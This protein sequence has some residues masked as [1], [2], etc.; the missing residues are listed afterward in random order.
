MP[1]EPYALCPMPHAL[2]PVV[3]HLSEK[4]YKFVILNGAKHNEESAGF[5]KILRCFTPIEQPSTWQI[6]TLFKHPLRNSAPLI[7]EWD[8]YNQLGSFTNL[9][10]TVNP[11]TVSLNNHLIAH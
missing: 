8:L 7:G 5:G 6:K 11:A 3:P 9:A 10:D 1:T 2:C 4:G